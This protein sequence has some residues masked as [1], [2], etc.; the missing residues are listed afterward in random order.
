MQEKK[1][2][3]RYCRS[4]AIAG[5][6]AVMMMP[7]SSVASRLTSTWVDQCPQV[8]GQSGDW[9]SL[10]RIEIR[11]HRLTVSAANDRSHFYL[12]VQRPVNLGVPG[13]RRMVLWIDPSGKREKRFGFAYRMVEDG[14]GGMN[15]SSGSAPASFSEMRGAVMEPLQ[16]AGDQIVYYD[17]PGADPEVITMPEEP[18]LHAAM[19]VEGEDLVFEFS[20]PLQDSTK[21]CELHVLPGDVFSLGIET[22]VVPRPPKPPG[23]FPDFA[24][25][26]ARAGGEQ[27]FTPPGNVKPGIRPPGKGREMDDQPKIEWIQVRLS[28]ARKKG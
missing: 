7:G 16:Q 22:I 10:P 3:G 9:V 21:Q 8:D 12:L 27:E 18:G 1:S 24:R 20:I 28:D 13:A 5:I 4:I 15:D 26:N 17:H 6:A 11:S 14:P 19:K 25:N 23:D 2:V